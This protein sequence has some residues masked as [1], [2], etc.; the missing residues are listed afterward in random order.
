V[1]RRYVAMTVAELTAALCRPGHV[2]FVAKRSAV[3]R[4]PTAPYDAR[5]PGFKTPVT[6]GMVSGL[7]GSRVRIDGGHGECGTIDVEDAFYLEDPL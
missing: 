5:K 1:K 4:M 6:F 3:S 2:L 7:R